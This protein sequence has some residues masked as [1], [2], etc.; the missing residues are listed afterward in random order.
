MDEEQLLKQLIDAL[1]VLREAETVKD[2]LRTTYVQLD[3]G[4]FADLVSAVEKVA[5]ALLHSICGDVRVPLSRP[6]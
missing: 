6:F 3:S 1:A 5:E 4:W 2:D